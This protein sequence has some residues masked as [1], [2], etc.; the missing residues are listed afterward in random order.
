[1]T[2]RIVFITGTRADFGKLKLII[3]KVSKN[4]TFETHV[5]ATGMHMLSKYGFTYEEV[6]SSFPNFVYGFVNQNE[7]SS[8]D[9]ILSKT[10]L[11][12]SDYVREIS[13]DLIVVHG[14]RV[15]ALAGAVVGSLNHIHVAHIEGGEVSGTIDDSIRHAITKFA[16]SHFVSDK[17]SFRRLL[18]MG[19]N[20]SSI[21]EIGSPD[22]EVMASKELPPLEEAL[23]HYAIPFKHYSLVLFHPV[24]SEIDSLGLHVRELVE[25]IKTSQKNYIVI[26]PNNDPGTEI[27]QE[28]YRKNLNFD[29]CRYFPSIRFEY[30]LTMLRH[31]EAIIG[32]SSAGVHEAPFYSV[33]SI[34]IGTRQ[35]G[36][37]KNLNILNVNPNKSE[38]LSAITSLPNYENNVYSNEFGAD[39]FNCSSKFLDIISSQKFWEIKTQKVFHDTLESMS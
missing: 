13:P 10:I 12:F 16:H 23:A 26:Q 38:I 20:N 39:L 37:T 6:K 25:S 28:Y 3:S 15:E 19:E 1:M 30:F 27:I 4:T 5:F 35:N 22:F 29:M 31:A 14:D 33:P 8:L 34:N 21:F 18:N 32:N 7:K 17:T 36:R 24:T 9:E 2:K 11:G